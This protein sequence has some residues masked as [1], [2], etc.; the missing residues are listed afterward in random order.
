MY[1]KI[2]NA[3][4]LKIGTTSIPFIPIA[5]TNIEDINGYKTRAPVLLQSVSA[6]EAPGYLV[7]ISK[8]LV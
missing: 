1:K 4:K 7:A 6:K 3:K 5:R 8:A 2:K